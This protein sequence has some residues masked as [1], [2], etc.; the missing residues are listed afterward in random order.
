MKKSIVKIGYFS[1]AYESNAY[2]YGTPTWFADAVA[3]GR[4]FEA[5]PRGDLTEVYA[6]GKRVIADNAN[7]GYDI[8]LQLLDIVDDIEEDWLGNTVEAT[9]NHVVEKSTG[10]EFPKIGLCICYSTRAG[11]YEVEWYYQCQVSK[12]PNRSGKTSEGKFDPQY[13]DV[14]LTC[15]P[16]EH[17]E[18]ASMLV[19]YRQKLTELP[20][21]TVA[22]PAVAADNP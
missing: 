5:T 11:A 18:P 15:L 12:R 16:R 20:T 4:S 14:E 1:V 2:A 13:F 6:N 10:T 9:T 21:T 3:G 19:M 17:D 7:D 22:T 8:K